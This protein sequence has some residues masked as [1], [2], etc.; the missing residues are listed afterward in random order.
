[1]ENNR[2][3]P[4]LILTVV[5]STRYVGWKTLVPR[6]AQRTDNELKPSPFLGKKDTRYEASSTT[7]KYFSLVPSQIFRHL[8]ILQHRKM[9]SWF[10][11]AHC[12]PAKS[13]AICACSVMLNWRPGAHTIQYK[14]LTVTLF[15]RWLF[16]LS[17][18]MVSLD[19]QTFWRTYFS[20]VKSAQPMEYVRSRRQLY[21]CSNYTAICIRF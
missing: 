21:I 14:R 19:L 11:L 10:L 3:Q 4:G 17:W 1:V 15:W 16:Q 8:H 6:P 9:N 20:E 18:F 5:P 12:D 13:T 7:A 2:R